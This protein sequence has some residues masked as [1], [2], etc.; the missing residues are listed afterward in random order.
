MGYFKVRYDSRVVIYNRK[1]F[2]RLAIENFV[3]HPRAACAN[4]TLNL[5]GK[6]FDK[7]LC[8]ILQPKRGKF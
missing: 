7:H 4:G 5:V 2:I 8:S 6:A 3:V 1:M